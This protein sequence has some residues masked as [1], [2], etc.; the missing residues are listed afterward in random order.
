MAR[1]TLLRSCGWL[2]HVLLSNTGCY[3]EWWAGGSAL[4]K[5]LSSKCLFQQCSCCAFFFSPHAQGFLSLLPLFV[6]TLPSRM[7]E[8]LR[9]SL[10]LCFSINGTSKVKSGWWVRYLVMCSASLCLYN[11]LRERCCFSFKGTQ[12]LRQWS[13]E[14]DEIGVFFFR[15]RD[16]KLL[17]VSGVPFL[18]V[19]VSCCCCAWGNRN[20]WCVLVHR[21]Q[22]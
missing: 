16:G 9:V 12:T 7:L 6:F 14:K 5:Q 19:C 1:R 3:S 18:L 15:L 11:A 2:S 21:L 22:K 13:H 17:V 10:L 4:S 20:Y 8:R